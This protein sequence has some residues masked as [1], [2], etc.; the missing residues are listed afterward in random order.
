MELGL[1][2]GSK[3]INMDGLHSFAVAMQAIYM[4]VVTIILIITAIFIIVIYF[5]LRKNEKIK[6]PVFLFCIWMCCV[7]NFFFYGQIKYLKSNIQASYYLSINSYD[8]AMDV[9]LDLQVNDEID[10]KIVNTYNK[11]V[12]YY[13]NNGK[14][15]ECINFID[16][17][18]DKYYDFNYSEQ[19][20]PWRNYKFDYVLNSYKGL[21]NEF[22]SENKKQQLF[23]IIV[24]IKDRYNYEVIEREGF[25]F[26]YDFNS[27]EC[28]DYI[29]EKGSVYF[30]KIGMSE[31]GLSE[32]KREV[33][34]HL[35]FREGNKMYLLCDVVLIS[36]YFNENEVNNLIYE[37]T[38]MY[39]FLNN[40]LYNEMFDEKDKK[41]IIKIDDD[42]ISLLNEELINKMIENDKGT[43]LNSLINRVPISYMV[44]SKNGGSYQ[45]FW[46]K[47]DIQNG[48]AKYIVNTYGNKVNISEINATRNDINILPVICVNTDIIR[49]YGIIERRKQEEQKI[50]LE[51]EKKEEAIKKNE[52]SKKYSVLLREK[53][54]AMKTVKEYNDDA[55]VED[56]DTILIGKNKTYYAEEYTPIAWI[57][58]EKDDE[59][60]LLLTKYCID[61]YPYNDYLYIKKCSY[62][63]RNNAME[64]FFDDDENE[65]IMNTKIVV[66]KNDEFPVNNDLEEIE[67]KTFFL[68]ID[69]I[70]KY[71][72]DDNGKVLNNKLKTLCDNIS[73]DYSNELGWWLRDIG[74]LWWTVAY[75]DSDGN[76]SKRGMLASIGLVG[77]RYAM[78]VDIS[79]K[80]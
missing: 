77:L 78:W 29:N 41:A 39:N 65:H 72:T 9:Y 11:G 68:S 79:D 53:I 32:M 6:I 2:C 16:K 7:I 15:R 5:R 3:R 35:L 57:L 70:K 64:S 23:D 27:Y 60:A 62:K 55:T 34:W 48:K 74:E 18:E 67:R 38:D 59:K 63:N 22:K 24:E 66:S 31:M 45:K 25:D 36:R 14:Y 28:F 12:E 51:K 21:Y 69:D 50:K 76:L 42:N 10:K 54:K 75:I 30:G 80:N 44:D 43:Y 17:T 71:F 52:Q 13:Y 26:N 73:D 46:V 61:S 37:K 56:F 58:L 33:G 47:S 19:Y 20:K 49:E 40:Y 1:L 4:F 8:K